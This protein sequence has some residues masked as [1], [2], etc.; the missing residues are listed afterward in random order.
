M[1]NNLTNDS[2]TNDSLFNVTIDNT[3]IA[4]LKQAIKWGKLVAIAGFASLAF[5]CITYFSRLG[6][7]LIKGASTAEVA[8]F[9]ITLTFVGIVFVLLVILNLFM[10]R[11]S[12]YTNIGINNVD[13]Q[14][15]N[16]GIGQL[17]AYFKLM[18]IVI[19]IFFGI[20][21]LVLLAAAL[22]QAFR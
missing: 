17:H 12:N 20:V 7:A 5:N 22:G 6:T 4:Y 16:R 11:F 1:E 19:I 8:T 14:Q 3:S 21:L 10:L 18:G 13:Q 15:F 2:L 9:A